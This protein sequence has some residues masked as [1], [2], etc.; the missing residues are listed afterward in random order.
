MVCL[1]LEYHRADDRAGLV[2]IG[3]IL[4]RIRL[5]AHRLTRVSDSYSGSC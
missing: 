2:A 3:G 4:A 5:D 1:V